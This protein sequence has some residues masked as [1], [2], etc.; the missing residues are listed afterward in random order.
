MQQTVYFE[1]LTPDFVAYAE[2]YLITEE[3]IIEFGR[4][5]DP[6][7]FHIDPIAAKNSMFGQLVAPGTLIVCARSWLVNRL[8]K[9][10]AY[11]AGLGVEH[12]NLLKPVVA[13]DTLRLEVRVREAR[14]SRSRPDHGIVHTYNAL[15]NQHN[16][17]VMELTPK[18]LVRTRDSAFN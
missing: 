8:D 5:F 2:G 15:Y 16:E 13:G 14:L 9:I 4:R 11:S 6:Q 12:M 7:P 17:Q 10:P 1:D 18:L 3:E